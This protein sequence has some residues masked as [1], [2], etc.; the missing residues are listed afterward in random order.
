M[1]T[2]QQP[3][4]GWYADPWPSPPEGL[5]W[6][7]G[8]QWTSHTSVPG[9]GAVD[10]SW[11]RRAGAC[12]IDGFIV[13]SI[14]FV[15]GIPG[16][17]GLQRDLQAEGERLER[18][19]AD[20]TVG[21]AFADYW[22]GIAGA[23]LDRWVW[24]ALL[25]AVAAVAYHALMLRTRSATVGKR[26]LRLRVVPAGGDGQLSWSVVARRLAAQFGPGWLILPLGLASGSWT[27]LLLV[28]LVASVFQLVDHL[29]AARSDRRAVH[30]LVAGTR[31]LQDP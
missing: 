5:R 31:V 30:D 29:W 17:I 8:G 2:G 7:D 23:W 10:A 20:G 28:G 27:G 1:S 16:Q 9:H 24:L 25:P 19:V 3:P 21:T 11:W 26:A 18:S 12:L 6:W 22:S 15:V 14:G 4:A 13:G